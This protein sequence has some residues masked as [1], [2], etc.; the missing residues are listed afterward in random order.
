MNFNVPNWSQALIAKSVG[1][2]PKKVAVRHEDDR[3]IAFL[4]YTPH[5]EILVDKTTGKT[6]S[7]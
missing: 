1:L 4:Q 6:I 3:N 7:C 5:R 2:D